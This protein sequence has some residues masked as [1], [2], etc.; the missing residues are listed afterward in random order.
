MPT[1]TCHLPTT[2]VSVQQNIII[3]QEQSPWQHTKQQHTK[4][5]TQTLF[6]TILSKKNHHFQPQNWHTWI[7][8]RLTWVERA[9][10]LLGESWTTVPREN[11]SLCTTHTLSWA[12]P[13][14]SEITSASV[15]AYGRKSVIY[16]WCTQWMGYINSRDLLTYQHETV[17]YLPNWPVINLT[18]SSIP[19]IQIMNGLKTLPNRLFQEAELVVRTPLSV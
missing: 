17:Q 3:Q 15:F 5:L 12:R 9:D 18:Y 4:T 1:S 14:L 16:Y 6:P 8:K 19:N 7:L 10:C 2:N 11:P 13:S